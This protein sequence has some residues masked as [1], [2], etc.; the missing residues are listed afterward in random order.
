MEEDHFSGLEQLNNTEQA[1]R[2]LDFVSSAGGAGELST[3]DIQNK[4]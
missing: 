3:E 4:S 2:D 1:K